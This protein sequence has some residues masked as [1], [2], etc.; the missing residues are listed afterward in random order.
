[1]NVQASLKLI[2]TSCTAAVYTRRVE[3]LFRMAEERAGRIAAKRTQRQREAVPLFA[4]QV[5]DLTAD[6]VQAAADRHA[7]A[8]EQ[9]CRELQARGDDFR[10]QVRRL[11][12]SEAF[13]EMERRRAILPPT[14]EYYADHWRRMRNSCRRSEKIGLWRW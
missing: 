13:A 8:F 12:S 4:D 6:Q 2:G 7:E 9:C 10:E 1:M 14:S 5:P 11:V 3:N